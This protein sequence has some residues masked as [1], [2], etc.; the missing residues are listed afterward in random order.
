[1][2]TPSDGKQANPHPGGATTSIWQGT[3]ELPRYPQLQKSGSCDVC[4][5]GAGIAGLSVAYHLAREGKKVIVLDDGPIGGGET[6]RTTAHL[7]DAMDD[8]IHWLEH[9]HG[10]EGARLAVASHGAAINRIQ[11]IIQLEGI[12]CDFERLDGYLMQREPGKEVEELQKEAA[13]AARAG[14]TDVSL[15]D[16]APIANFESGTALRFPSQGQFH[17]LKYLAGLAHAIVDKYHGQI[18]CDTHV[19]GVEGGDPCNVKIEGGV[20]LSANCV[21]VC[22]NSSISD[23]VQTHIKSEPSRTYAIAALVPR[24]SVDRALYWDLGD[25]YHYVRLQNLD[26]PHPGVLKGD[27]LWDALIVGGEDHKVGHDTRPDERWGALERWM[28]ER[29]PQAREVVYRWSGQIIEPSDGLAYIG[30]NPDGA[31]N[32]FMAMGDSGQGMTHGTIAG[33]VISDL[34]VG[35]ENQWAS[36]YDPKRVS[37]RA[38]PIAEMAMHNVDVAVQYAKGFL[39][40]DLGSVDDLKPGEGKVIRRGMKKIAAYRGE[41]GRVIEKS[42]VCTHLKC[43]VEWNGAEKSWDCPCHGSRFAPTGEVLN[44]PAIMALE[45]VEPEKGGGVRSEA[46][47]RKRKAKA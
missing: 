35:R 21:A 9:I 43:I 13:A 42:A 22:T 30:R 25:V 8:R 28:R 31:E 37:L 44:G 47:Q 12:D 34:I 4:V 32:V 24:G 16:R 26:E 36:L 2:T 38:T 33:M 18:F 41:D 29:W 7:T 17:I 6:G 5:I 40:P 46:P 23:Y 19:E 15:V 3:I 1:M 10:A 11:Q 39:A 45:D 14:L 20:Q 27:T